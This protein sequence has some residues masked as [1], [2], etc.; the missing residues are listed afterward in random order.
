MSGA[1][2]TSFPDVG[3]STG[4]A[5]L[6]QDDAFVN[7]IQRNSYLLARFMTGKQMS[8][9][10]QGGES[11][12]D[13]IYFDLK[14]SYAHYLPN[15]S[16]SYNNPQVLSQWSVPWRFSKAEAVWTAQELGL[17]MGQMSRVARHHRYKK[18]I[19][20]KLMNL[21]TDLTEGYENDCFTTPDFT[22]MEA[23][24]GQTPQSLGSFITEHNPTATI[25][26]GSITTGGRPGGA[27]TY[28][29]VQ[30]IDPTAASVDGKW[31]N[32]LGGY[33]GATDALDPQQLIMAN[34]LFNTFAR[35][36]KRLSYKRM[37]KGPEFSDPASRPNVIGCSLDGST[38][39]EDALRRSND[40]LVAAGRQDPSFDASFRGVEVEYIEGF[41]NA[42]LYDNG[43]GGYE[44][45]TASAGTEGPRFWFINGLYMLHV[46][47]SDRYFHYIPP[48]Q[49]SAQ[50]MTTIS[51]VD[52]WHNMVC[53][54]RRRHGLVVPVSDVTLPG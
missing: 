21:F 25:A 1:P 26:A 30:G 51:M 38:L 31:G 22:S 42:A 45:E 3:L 11:I 36:F 41:D 14:S 52:C 23:S 43:S 28:T 46:W 18:I 19:N 48:F 50:P 35:M 32:Q 24:G 44:T 4:P 40:L 15:A 54:S 12:R 34:S 6:T 20:A 47:H 10:L 5:F 37:P 9:M 16:F 8:D 53:R 33:T 39:F 2:I 13:D 7:E 29:T 17:N 49:P 27:T